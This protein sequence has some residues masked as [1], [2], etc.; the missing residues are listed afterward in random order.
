VLTQPDVTAKMA[1]QGSDVVRTTPQEF[2][3]FVQNEVKKY[4]EIVKASGL[5]L[6]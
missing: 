4:G 2:G 1:E 5:K 6:Q 3:R